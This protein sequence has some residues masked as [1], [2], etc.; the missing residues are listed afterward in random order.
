M[1][2]SSWKNVYRKWKKKCKPMNS[3]LR[4]ELNGYFTSISTITI[5]SLYENY[6]KYFIINVSCSYVNFGFT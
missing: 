1:N 3:S 5:I 6:V 2:N 4:S